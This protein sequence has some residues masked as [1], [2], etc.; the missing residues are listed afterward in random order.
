MEI[1]HDFKDYI[2]KAIEFVSKSNDVMFLEM[3]KEDNRLKNKSYL[4]LI[5]ITKGRS[6]GISCVG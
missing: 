3:L 5:P 1:G 6:E 4:Y 2:L